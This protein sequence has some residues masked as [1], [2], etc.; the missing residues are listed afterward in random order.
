MNATCINTTKNELHAILQAHREEPL[1]EQAA[2]A[3]NHRAA[4]A[5]DSLCV[6]EKKRQKMLELQ[7]L[8]RDLHRRKNTAQER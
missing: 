7:E 6:S 8:Q 5:D 1:P 2:H 4:S 3:A